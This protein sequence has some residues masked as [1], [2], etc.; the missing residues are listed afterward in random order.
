MSTFRARRGV[1]RILTTSILSVSA[2]LA[3]GP[4]GAETIGITSAVNLNAAL[5]DRP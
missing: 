4:A 1:S 2:A 5:G 3:A